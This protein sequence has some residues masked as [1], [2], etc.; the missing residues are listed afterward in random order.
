MF[1][2]KVI[3]VTGGTGSFGKHFI[4]RILNDYKP[5]KIIIFSRDE[6]K[7]YEMEKEFNNKKVLRFF[8]GDVRDKDR[9]NMAFKNVDYVVHT[10]ALK[11]VPACEYNPFE[12][13]K[14]NIL[15]AQNIVE[16]CIN[17]GVKKLVALST[18]KA[19]SPVNLYG[20]TK[21]CMEKIFLTANNYSTVHGTHFM[22]VR[23]GNVIGS[24]G[25]VIPY[26]KQLVSDGVTSLPITDVRMTRFWITLDSA[27]DLVLDIFNNGERGDIFIPK[28]KSMKMIDLIKVFDVDYHIIGIRQGEKIYESLISEDESCYAKELKDKYIINYQYNNKDTFSYRSDLNDDYLTVLKLKEIIGVK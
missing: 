14:T 21:A 13:V 1:N 28:I 15:G 24:R 7:Q 27:V 2:D 16:A 11:H 9:L 12:A 18:D 20:A 4:A 10:A 26:F 3:L 23:Y 6:L 25:S 17:N 8:I 5:K 19:S 22:C